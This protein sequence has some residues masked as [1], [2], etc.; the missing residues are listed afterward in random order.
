MTRNR[1]I[2]VR[3]FAL[4]WCLIATSGIAWAQSSNSLPAQT[5]VSDSLANLSPTASGSH[6]L[7]TTLLLAQASDTE[8]LPLAPSLPS[9]PVTPAAP[10]QAPAE[11]DPLTELARR[12]SAEAAKKEQQI[13]ANRQANSA[14]S[15]AS[16][17]KPL[18]MY[19]PSPAADRATENE[20]RSKELLLANPNERKALGKQ[21]QSLVPDSD[22]NETKQL[23][24]F[25]DSGSW[26]LNTITALGVVIG[27]IIA[28]RLILNKISGRAVLGGRTGVVE[29]LSRTSISPRNQVMLL[30]LGQRIIVVSEGPNGVRTLANL[31]DP[32]EV[33]GLLTHIN[34]S[35]PGS[36]TQSFN[37][38][39]SRADTQMDD[40]AG[41]TAEHGADEDEHLVDKTRNELSNLLSRIRSMSKGGGRD[42]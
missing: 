10:S 15:T 13:S 29:V 28:M 32:N 39:L 1:S 9:N 12:L 23:G 31:D 36:I 18:P 42:A 24:E 16:E 34:S 17:S 4:L 5:S 26:I 14:A 30:R 38:Q 6:S 27:L 25:N 20:V 41:F 40:P 2:L 21:G 33:A 7:R 35:K 37:Q 19:A 8:S 3:K 11:K 22:P